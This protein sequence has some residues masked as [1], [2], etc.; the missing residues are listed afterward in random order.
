MGSI[1]FGVLKALPAQR[2]RGLVFSERFK[3]ASEVE[4]N[5]GV[6]VGSVASYPTILNAKTVIAKLK[7]A[8]L[9]SQ[10]IKINASQTIT[11]AAGNVFGSYDNASVFNADDLQI[12]NWEKFKY[13]SIFK[14]QLEPEEITAY[15]ENKMWSYDRNS[16]VLALTMLDNDHDAINNVTKDRSGN[17]NDAIFGDGTTASTFPT[18]LDR[19]GYAFPLPTSFSRTRNDLCGST[20]AATITILISSMKLGIGRMWHLHDTSNSDFG[21]VGLYS[22][23]GD[24]Y[25]LHSGGGGARNLSRYINLNSHNLITMVFKN[26]KSLLLYVNDNPVITQGPV[27]YVDFG[28]FGGVGGVGIP[29]RTDNIEANIHQTR[30]H[31][32][33]LNTT[34]IADLHLEMMQ[35]INRV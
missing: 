1:N 7:H 24:L 30:I 28:G 19:R 23:S 29:G 12:D 13:V 15:E 8:E 16:C 20:V 4:K 25:L 5:G 26:D 18:K 22:N 11:I 32:T 33:A 2:K 10:T 14:E 17:G 3:N 31:N 21:G 35:S 27:S 9:T 34:Q 6:I